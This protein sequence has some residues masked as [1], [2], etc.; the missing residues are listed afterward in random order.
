[1]VNIRFS[2]FFFF[3]TAL[4]FTVYIVN[5]KNI[6]AVVPVISSPALIA[7]IVY[8]S[9]MKVG[10]SGMMILHPKWK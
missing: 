7:F 9:F 6:F 3:V 8:D 4:T 10:K 2:P 5:T 1:M